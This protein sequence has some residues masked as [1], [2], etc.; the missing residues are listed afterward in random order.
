MFAFTSE[1]HLVVNEGTFE[2]D[3]DISALNAFETTISVECKWY[4]LRMKCKRQTGE[5]FEQFIRA[6]ASVEDSNSRYI[7][8]TYIKY[9]PMPIYI[10]DC[11]EIDPDEKAINLRSHVEMPELKYGRDHSF[12]EIIYKALDVVA[13]RQADNH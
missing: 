10:A 12:E 13:C 3:V 11:Y 9:E 6:Y 1:G 8:L 7:V 4:G 5:S 2:N